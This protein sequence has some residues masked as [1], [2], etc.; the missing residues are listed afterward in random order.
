MQHLQSQ[1]ILYMN[2]RHFINV[3][4]IHIPCMAAAAAAKN[5]QLLDYT[6]ESSRGSS[7]CRIAKLTN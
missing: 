5:E 3:N 6:P 2:C 1:Y 7:Q 4:V